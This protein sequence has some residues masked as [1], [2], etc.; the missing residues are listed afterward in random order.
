MP[1][2]TADTPSRGQN[3]AMGGGEVKHLADPVALGRLIGVGAQGVVH[4]AQLD[5]ERVAVKTIDVGALGLT[6]PLRRPDLGSGDLSA[7][8][9][10]LPNNGG[11]RRRAALRELVALKALPHHENVVRLVGWYVEGEDAS[12]SLV[13]EFMPSDLHK[14]ASSVDALQTLLGIL[15]GLEHLHKNGVIHRDLKPSNV[16]LDQ[17]G[18]PKLGDLGVCFSSGAVTVGDA[19]A[20][21]HT[22]PRLQRTMT[23]STGTLAT[24]APEVA[25]GGSYGSSADMYSVGRLIQVLKH[26]SWRWR[27]ISA[28][29][30]LEAR[31]LEP[32]DERPTASQAR[33]FV[34]HA[35]ARAEQESII[36]LTA[37]FSRRL[38]QT[39]TYAC[40]SSVLRPEWYVTSCSNSGSGGRRTGRGSEPRY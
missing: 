13:M 4:E 6:D 30:E 18:K 14:D 28:V 39:V 35:M 26:A 32:P 40:G 36:G 15:R 24:M 5:G 1:R 22:A 37:T 2:L 11:G 21:A 33:E 38:V 10:E 27:G 7:M 3:R 17:D 16:L 31:C 19:A 29:D 20:G 8:L 34:E 23:P 9:D 25:R 12:I